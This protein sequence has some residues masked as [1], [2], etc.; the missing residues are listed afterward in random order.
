MKRLLGFAAALV[1]FGAA[2]VTP[3]QAVTVP[4]APTVTV[5]AAGPTTR[6]SVDVVSTAS[7]RGIGHVVTLTAP[8][9]QALGQAPGRGPRIVH[10]VAT[11]PSRTLT[12]GTTYGTLTDLA[13]GS[14]RPIRLQVLRQSR[15]TLTVTPIPGAV[16]V[17]A[18]AVH[19]DLP[20]ATWRGDQQSTITIYARTS[21]GTYSVDG[22]TAI[23]GTTVVYLPLPPGAARVWAVR[24]AGTT[25]SVTGATSPA[26]R[27]AIPGG[28]W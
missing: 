28:A 19:W 25:S 7:I 20:S 17:Q 15:V 3:A 18:R 21:V 12:P 9:V 14:R 26:V 2:T 24:A 4:L 6:V 1:A 27:V 16:L 13:D 22:Q 8:G 10:V 23:D 5:V 11:V